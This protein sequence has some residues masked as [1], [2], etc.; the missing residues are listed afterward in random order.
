MKQNISDFLKH[1]YEANDIKDV[2]EAF[3]NYPAEEE[4]HE[5][6]TES[7]IEEPKE[8]YSIY[9]IGDIVFVKNYEYHSKQKGNNHLFVIIDKNNMAVPME[10]IAMLISSKIE[11]VKYEANQL[12]PKNKINGLKK[13]SI[14]KK[15][16]V[17]KILNS[18]ILF[19]VGTIDE[20]TINLYKD[21]Y[22]L[23]TKKK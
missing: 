14:V 8:F 12:L 10:N 21:S 15:D 18:Q 1:M 7:F 9:D 13:D 17:Y 16:V 4:W 6:K 19:R 3:K 5:G 20:D 11:K 22:Q 2:S 23:L